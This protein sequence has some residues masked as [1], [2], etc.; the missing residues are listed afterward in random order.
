MTHTPGPWKVTIGAK[1]PPE[2][3]IT[4]S[5]EQG[6]GVKVRM[7]YVCQIQAFGCEAE[8]VNEANARLIAVA[9]EMLALLKELR[10]YYEHLD[11]DNFPATIR[12]LDELIAKAEP[13][14]VAFIV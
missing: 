5:L 11:C 1:Y 8:A 6:D 9:P 4:G 12:S 2:R 10:S 13:R 3:F 14:E 7:R